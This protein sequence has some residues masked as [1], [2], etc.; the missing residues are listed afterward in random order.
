M[1][2]KIMKFNISIMLYIMSLFLIKIK[3][4]K[5]GVRF[6]FHDFVLHYQYCV[7][8]VPEFVICLIESI[9]GT[10]GTITMRSPLEGIY[11]SHTHLRSPYYYCLHST[12]WG[13]RSLLEGVYIQSHAHFWPHCYDPHSAISHAPFWS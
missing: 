6:Y 4:S 13:H 2:A 7:I 1:E 9:Y 3:T 11:L 10:M 5:S 12:K 8:P